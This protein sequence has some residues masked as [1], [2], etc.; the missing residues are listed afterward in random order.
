M[1]WRLKKGVLRTLRESDGLTL[2]QAAMKVGISSRQLK[3]HESRR[4]PRTIQL[5]NVKAIAK[6]YHK[7]IEHIAEQADYRS[8]ASLTDS[9][10]VAAGKVATTAQLEPV[11][12]PLS[13][14]AL[15]KLGTLSQRCER[16]REL[17]LD[18]V[19]ID[20]RH[21][22]L[23]LM[24]L[25]WFKL[26][27]SR[28]KKHDGKQFVVI[29]DVD[30]HQGL[31]RPVRKVFDVDDGGKY[32]VVRWL[33]DETPFYTTIFALGEQQAD[34]L[35]PL[36]SKKRRAALV[37]RVAYRPPKARD[38]RGF[39]WYGDEKAP[40]EFG[41]ICDDILREIPAIPSPKRTA[42][43]LSKEHSAESATDSETI[44]PKP[45]RSKHRTPSE[46]A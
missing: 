29:G 46:A 17:G 38:W 14:S 28:P 16:E 30:D 6:A 9:Y 40:L 31:S 23:P 32:R 15:P 26:A 12:P 3:A 2:E 11:L 5:A 37:I 27:Y 39:Y 7:R 1:P 20:T 44:G 13:V 35:T 21:G 25:N 45:S 43:T 8:G 18:D 34:E 19:Q 4:P 24:G 33:D 22:K 10:E 42:K 36:A 41:F